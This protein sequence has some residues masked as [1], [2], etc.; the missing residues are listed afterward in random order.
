MVTVFLRGGLGNQ[1]F[2]AALGLNLAKKNNTDLVFDTVFLSDRFPRRNFSYR[3]FDLDVFSF[4]PHL[5]GFS[6]LADS[7]PIPGVWLG[8]D[9][10][11]IGAR[12]TLGF[13]KPVK[14]Q[15][16]AFDPDVLE[17]QGNL[18]LYGRWQSEKYFTDIADDVRA[19]FKFRHAL[20]GEAK[21]LARKI[22]SSNSVSL[23]VR[24]PVFPASLRP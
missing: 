9:F 4:G 5:T 6:R 12:S 20:E 1:M 18:L 19:A 7:F 16:D 13:Q 22:A 21:E 3:T 8:L 14:E 10:L 23:H 17:I 2:Q 11:S 15:T 24:R